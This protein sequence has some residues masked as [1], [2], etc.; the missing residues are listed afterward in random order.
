ME[1]GLRVNL[2]EGGGNGEG[3]H[4]WVWLGVGG[5]G[6]EEDG[7]TGVGS[8]RVGG[9]GEVSGLGGWVVSNG[10]GGKLR[11]R[12]EDEGP[13]VLPM[14]MRCLETRPIPFCSLD[15]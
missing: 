13:T 4:D 1:A 14:W 10:I 9:F 15:P 8:G 3:V 6:G 5:V 11:L 2:V 7:G 12:C